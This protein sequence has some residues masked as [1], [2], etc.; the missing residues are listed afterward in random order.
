GLRPFET[1]A[2]VIQRAFA[3][4]KARLERH[5]QGENARLA[6][7]ILM[8]LESARNCL[9]NE[10]TRAAYDDT[11]RSAL[12]SSLPPATADAATEPLGASG[13]APLDPLDPLNAQI[14]GL[15]RVNS[16]L[17]QLPATAAPSE[18][19]APATAPVPPTMYSY[20]G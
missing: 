11:L 2:D 8:E 3:N 7:R 20:A 9:L 6:K 15:E 1:N 12:Q 13:L 18:K 5:A 17:G 14:A 4:Q 16:L 19:A 10:E